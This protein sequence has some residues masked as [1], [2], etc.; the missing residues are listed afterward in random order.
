MGPVTAVVNRCRYYDYGTHVVSDHVYEVERG[1]G[2]LD[3]V[4]QSAKG[5]HHLQYLLL[6]LTK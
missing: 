6:W 4:K 1:D 2:N 3:P 5:T